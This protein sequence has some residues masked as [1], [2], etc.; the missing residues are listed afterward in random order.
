MSE[1]RG[2]SITAYLAGL[3]QRIESILLSG[4]DRLDVRQHLLD[5]IASAFVVCGGRTFRD[6]AA[7]C[8]RETG[9]I[10][11]PGSGAERVSSLDGAMLWAFAINSSVFE[12]GSREGA[13]HPGAVV[14]PTAIAY[15][16]GQSWD[17]IERAIV[18]GYDVMIRLAR[19]GNPDF[20]RKGFHPTAIIGS[21]GAAAT[22]SMLLGCDESA[23]QHALSLAAL[24]GGGLMASFRSGETQPLQ[25]AFSVRNGI[26][27]A[28]MARAGNRGYLRILEEGFYPAYLGKDP[29]PAVDQPLQY[30]YAI[31]GSYLKPYPGCRHVHPSID[32]LGEILN[33][34]KVDPTQIQG[35]VSRTYKIAVETEIEPVAS[36]GDAYFNVPYALAA[37]IVLGRNDWDAFDE[38]HFANERLVEVMKKVRVE[39]DPEME[40]AYPK[41][42]GAAVEIDVG[43]GGPLR[44]MVAH[45]LGEP[46]NPLPCSVTAEKFRGAAGSFLSQESL[47]RVADMLSFPSTMESPE[48]LFERLSERV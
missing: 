22:A 38:R 46:E 21:F 16:K 18:A 11:W 36:R 34:E 5:A 45:P 31:R 26:L 1:T 40:R 39:I 2:P 29:S 14:I 20:T 9:G 12:D 4:E 23:K 7:G 42:R 3:I 17:R 13:C 32:A 35:I 6:L 8:P 24:G 41:S 47:E 25:V 27:A 10:G 30:E 19:A 28:L 37:R 44:G 43:K 15:A 33:K 48:R